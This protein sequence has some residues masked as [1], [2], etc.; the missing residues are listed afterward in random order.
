M[1]RKISFI[2]IIMIIAIA[3]MG[4]FYKNYAKSIENDQSII[5]AEDPTGTELTSQRIIASIIT[6]TQ[7]IMVFVPFIVL[8]I[9]LLKFFFY[10]VKL[11]NLRLKKDK[12]LET[13]TKIEKTEEKIK[14]I[15]KVIPY[16]I[17]SI[18]VFFIISGIIQME[19]FGPTIVDTSKVSIVL[20]EPQ[21]SEMQTDI[22]R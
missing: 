14:K 12:T 11:A 22:I 7:V 2:L 18:I 17:V 1:K 20:V 13:Y 9:S 19:K 3:L 4:T 6:I 15:K 16:I 10:R 8:L 21:Y 5:T